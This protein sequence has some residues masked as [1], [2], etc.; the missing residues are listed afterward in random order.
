MTI[1]QP[2]FFA[3]VFLVSAA[4]GYV[5]LSELMPTA[6][7]R[8]M[9]ALAG[10]RAPAAA[11]VGIT[12]T[13]SV[14]LARWLAPLARASQPEQS[15][16]KSPL[17]IR[18]Y[19]A[20]LRSGR[21]PI[22]FFGAKTLLTV[23]LPGLLLALPWTS[24]LRFHTPLLLAVLLLFA[25]IGYYLPNVVLARIITRRQ[26][27][28]FEAFPDALDLM[29]VCVEAGLG[30]DAALERVG[31]E[32]VLESAAL[33]DEFHLVSLELRAGAS[34]ADALRNLAVRVSLEDIDAMVA[35][36]VQSDRFG[37][38]IADALRVHSES[39]K[40]KRR[41]IAEE[42]AAKLPVKLLL[43]LIFSIF[44]ALLTVLLGP[45]VVS[46]YRLLFPKL[47]GH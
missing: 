32:M 44:P 29:R 6:V 8:R 1:S 12:H 36:L 19:S 30:L 4:V 25:A 22:V 17:R 3:V 27:E 31:K 46:V 24:R 16:D 28:L 21:A 15:W 23:V 38:S 45:A 20:G 2:L 40:T 26:R 7:K 42:A 43:P 13:I 37:T 34:R 35:M 33:A 11:D 9:A 5:I 47:T 10:G 14:A 18:F 39:L 41:L